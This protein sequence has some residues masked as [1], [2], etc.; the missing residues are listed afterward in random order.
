[1]QISTVNSPSTFEK[2]PLVAPQN[3]QCSTASV[4]SERPWWPWTSAGDVAAADPTV[5]VR[6]QVPL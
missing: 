6:A 1:M 4:T 3:E 5:G 2:G